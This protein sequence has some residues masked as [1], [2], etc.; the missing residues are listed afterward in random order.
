VKPHPTIFQ[1]ALSALEVRPSAAVMV[2][3]SLEED[4]GGAQAL[5][6]RGILVDSD[7]RYPDVGD[8]LSDL[9]GLPAALG[10]VR[11]G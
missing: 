3:D 2:G 5:G 6:M 10:L 9:L 8:R 11:P 7:D 1:A 4:V